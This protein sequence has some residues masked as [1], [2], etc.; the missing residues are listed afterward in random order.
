[1]S[2]DLLSTLTIVKEDCSHK[3]VMASHPEAI[4][5]PGDDLLRIVITGGVSGIVL[6]GVML[7]SNDDQLGMGITLIPTITPEGH[8]FS[9]QLE[10]AQSGVKGILLGCARLSAGQIELI[11]Q[12]LLAEAA[13]L[14]FEASNGGGG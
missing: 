11:A 2:E 10:I 8:A 5:K 1:M 3:A 13:L 6:D 7:A 12:R 4:A 9:V 14:K